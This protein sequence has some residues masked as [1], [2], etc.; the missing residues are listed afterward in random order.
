MI[1]LNLHYLF[2]SRVLLLFVTFGG[3]KFINQNKF[4]INDGHFQIG[5]G[6][7]WLG[8]QLLEPFDT[9]ERGKKCKKCGS[10]HLPPTAGTASNQF[11][12]ITDQSSEWSKKLLL[13]SPS[14][15][16]HMMLSCKHF[17]SQAVTTSWPLTLIYLNSR[18]WEAK[19]IIAIQDCLDNSWNPRFVTETVTILIILR[20]FLILY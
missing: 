16:Y 18:L 12:V 13:G 14:Q 17:I 20:Q 3:S 4:W 10:K 1:T 19:T 6:K 15:T 5:F 2:C 7:S 8:W 11:R 9:I